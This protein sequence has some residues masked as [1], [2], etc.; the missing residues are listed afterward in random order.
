MISAFDS[1]L[2]SLRCTL[3]R[4]VESVKDGPNSEWDALQPEPSNLPIRLI[5]DLGA[6][7]RR[8]P[9]SPFSSQA[10]SCMDT[11]L[12]ERGQSTRAKPFPALTRGG[13]SFEVE[14]YYDTLHPARTASS[15]AAAAGSGSGSASKAFSP[16]SPP[17][18]AA[19]YELQQFAPITNRRRHKGFLGIL[20]DGGHFEHLM[21]S[22][23]AP[24]RGTADD[25]VA[26]G[27]RVKVDALG[28][29]LLKT[30][31]KRL[32]ATE[33]SKKASRR[34]SVSAE[35]DRVAEG[36]GTSRVPSTTGEGRLGAFLGKFSASPPD[37][38]LLQPRTALAVNASGRGSVSQAT[39][40]DMDRD[41]R[42]HRDATVH[43]ISPTR[44]SSHPLL[45]VTLAMLRVA[46]VRALDSHSFLSDHTN[47][48]PSPSSHYSIDAEQ[49]DFEQAIAQC[50]YASVP[51]L[52]VLPPSGEH[53]DADGIH[54]VGVSQSGP[55]ALVECDAQVRCD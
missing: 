23:I 45:A 53:T 17:L 10:F 19:R 50:S 1:A 54:A 29:L 8:R 49:C 31:E 12:G 11:L 16:S 25:L 13:I 52:V 41:V 14:A 36:A 21:Q 35:K 42:L 32:E 4:L 39:A 9:L 5:V 15:A 43:N 30:E 37:V 44:S 47:R 18:A 7:P 2:G 55:Q 24:N 26:V 33:R 22:C 20:I 6:D 3:S 27:M 51:F 46:G 28:T 48:L 34:S 40:A 38:I